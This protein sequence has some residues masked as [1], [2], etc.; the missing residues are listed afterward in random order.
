MDME[1]LTSVNGV[2]GKHDSFGRVIKVKRDH[3]PGRRYIVGRKVDEMIS[4]ED[5]NLQELRDGDTGLCN[6]NRSDDRRRR[7]EKEKKMR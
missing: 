5:L 3:K 6:L 2:R 1:R 7:E 4:Y